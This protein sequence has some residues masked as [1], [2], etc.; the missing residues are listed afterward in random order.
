MNAQLGN[1]IAT[2]MLI[3]LILK[4]DSPARVKQVTMAMELHVNVSKS[5]NVADESFF[6]IRFPK[7]N[8]FEHTGK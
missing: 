1:I 3:V 5:I 7:E 4:A 2:A 6:P 8:N